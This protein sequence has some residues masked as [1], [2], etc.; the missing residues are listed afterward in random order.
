V[1]ACFDR[2]CLYDVSQECADF[3]ARMRKHKHKKHHT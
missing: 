3:E 2:L 1:E